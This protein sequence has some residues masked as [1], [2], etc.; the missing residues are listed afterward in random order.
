MFRNTF[1][2]CFFIILIH[3]FHNNNA[4]KLDFKGYPQKF[5][6]RSATYSVA[7]YNNDT[8]AIQNLKSKDQTFVEI[9]YLKKLSSV[10]GQGNFAKI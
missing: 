10:I 6:K 3:Y 4:N 2:W 5:Q 1:I 8:T 9:F 7:Y